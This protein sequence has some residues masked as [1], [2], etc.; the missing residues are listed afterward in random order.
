MGLDTTHDAF[1]GGYGSYLILREALMH[2][3]GYRQTKDYPPT[4]EWDGDPDFDLPENKEIWDSARFGE[5]DNWPFDPVL[6]LWAHE[7]CEGVIRPVIAGQ[8][9]DRIEDLLPKIHDATLIFAPA[10]ADPQ[11]EPAGRT[12]TTMAKQFMDGLREASRAG[13][14]VEFH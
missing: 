2:A 5:I 11:R 3:A 9:A 14:E 4:F 13:E 10:W 6:F 7:D 8:I 1:H 12:T